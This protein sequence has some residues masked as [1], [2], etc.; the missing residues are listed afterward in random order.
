MFFF[1]KIFDFDISKGILSVEFYGSRFELLIGDSENG[2]NFQCSISEITVETI[3][4]F[5]A[6]TSKTACDRQEFF[7]KSSSQ[8]MNCI[9]S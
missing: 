3:E 2:K 5:F 9:I 6:S 7:F 1:L 4:I 8:L